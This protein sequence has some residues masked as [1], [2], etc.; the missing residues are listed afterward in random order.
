M[1]V[2]IILVLAVAVAV[3][4]A[5][6]FSG[7]ETGIYKLSR[8]R[9]RLG[10]EKKQVLF[11]VLGKSLQDST[12]LLIAILTGTNLTYYVI[13]SIVTYIFA[14]KFGAGHTA[15]LFAT[16]L[17]APLLFIFVDL[18]PKNIF[19]YYADF[20]MPRVA[21]VLYGTKSILTWC[22]VVPVLKIVLRTFAK[23]TGTSLHSEAVITSSE[24][25][26]I[27]AVI[28]ETREEGFL[29]P[30]QT[31]M[32]NRLVGITNIN[33]RSVM[34][35]I[36]KVQ[37]VKV[38]SDKSMLL[39]RLREWGFTRLPVYEGR[40][41]SIIGFVN[42]YDVLNRPEEF[43]ELRT[44]MQPIR[45]LTADTTVIDAMT[46]MRNE[47]HNIALVIRPSHT[48]REKAVGIVTIKDLVEELV[49]ELAEQE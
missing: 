1:I 31:D 22:A 7:A 21:P 16:L 2:K 43:G 41:E 24:K 12:G 5:G 26:H 42:I 37:A 48:G 34:V 9:L 6:I 46:L 45:K 28:H 40:A 23:M 8:L 11:I 36:S 29:S 20:L 39:E 47:N 38:D 49:G 15:E 32:I 19:F 44:F 25:Y 35:P 30:L 13:T 3:I 18:I 4:L 17:T 33:I 10:I 14:N 27:S